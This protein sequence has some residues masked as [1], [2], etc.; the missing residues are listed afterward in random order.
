MT[1]SSCKTRVPE[2]YIFVAD[3][4]SLASFDST[5][6]TLKQSDTVKSDT[7]VPEKVIQGHPRS[8]FFYQWKAHVRLLINE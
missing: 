4:V 1:L 6:L 3:S 7:K 8:L 2:L 5:L